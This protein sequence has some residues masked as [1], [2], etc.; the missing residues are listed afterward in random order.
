MKLKSQRDP[1][2]SRNSQKRFG[3]SASSRS[4]SDDKPC[5]I[6]ALKGQNSALWHAAM[7]SEIYALNQL[8]CWEENDGIENMKVLHTNLCFDV[9]ESKTVT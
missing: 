8:D 6:E 1:T 2:R 5:V 3:L 9:R 7:R 4:Q